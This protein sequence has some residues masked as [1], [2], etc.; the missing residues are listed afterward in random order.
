MSPWKP[1][2]DLV[3]LAREHNQR[4]EWRMIGG[5]PPRKV[6]IG[7]RRSKGKKALDAEASVHRAQADACR[8]NAEILLDGKE[9]NRAYRYWEYDPV[10]QEFVRDAMEVEIE[11]YFNEV[12]GI[13]SEEPNVSLAKNDLAVQAPWRGH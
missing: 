6:T 11:R 9:N 5:P 2:R 3:A 4:W 1:G 8:A 10:R 7:T 12:F 13:E